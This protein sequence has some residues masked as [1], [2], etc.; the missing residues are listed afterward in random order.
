LSVTTSL[1]AVDAFTA[2]GWARPAA[3]ISGV[4]V[5]CVFVNAGG[6]ENH[7]L[8]TLGSGNWNVFNA[9]DAPPNFTNPPVSGEWFFWALAADAGGIYGYNARQ[10]DPA[11]EKK[12]TTFR[13]FTPTTI[14]IGNDNAATNNDFFKGDIA[15]VK[16]WNARLTD[17]EIYRERYSTTPRRW[18]D[19]NRWSHL[20]GNAQDN[21]RARNWTETGT[22][23]WAQTNP[24]IAWD[25]GAFAE[26]TNI[27]TERKSNPPT[28]SIAWTVA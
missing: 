14:Y 16:V 7:G 9:V 3:A 10:R 25:G 1:P 18:A 12:T 2:C 4:E 11:I 17:S 6:T 26:N 24:L 27:L 20:F 21:F 22:V 8:G 28:A 19:L 15:Y 5:V 23:T 13:T